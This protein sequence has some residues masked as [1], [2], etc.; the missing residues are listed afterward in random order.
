MYTFQKDLFEVGKVERTVRTNHS[1]G[2]LAKEAWL[3]QFNKTKVYRIYGHSPREVKQL[4][5]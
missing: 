5:T 4:I 1:M 3:D 2:N